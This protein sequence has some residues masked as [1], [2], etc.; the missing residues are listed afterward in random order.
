MHHSLPTNDVYDVPTYPSIFSIEYAF[1]IDNSEKN[2]TK[3]LDG[4]L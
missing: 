1:I 2:L 3:F 4:D